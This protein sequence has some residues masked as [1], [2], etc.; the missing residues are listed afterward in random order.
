MKVLADDEVIRLM[1]AAFKLYFKPTDEEIVKLSKQLDPTNGSLWLGAL[2]GLKK[3]QCIVV[4]DRVKEDGVFGS[5]K[6]TITNITSFK[7]R[8]KDGP[9]SKCELSSDV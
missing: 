9:T 2:K 3:G 4:G 8:R 6:P 7:E 1:Q 5:V